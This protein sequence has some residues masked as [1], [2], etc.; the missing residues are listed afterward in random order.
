VPTKSTLRAI[1]LS[2]LMV[3][4]ILGISQA[5]GKKHDVDC[6]KQFEFSKIQLKLSA[7]VLKKI[8]GSVDLGSQVQG[9]VDKWTTISLDNQRALCDA[10]SKSTEADFPTREY[11]TQLENFRAW[12]LDFLKIV[13][14][15][16][17][18]DDK[19]A[20]AVA[21]GKGPNDPDV[22]QLKND[23]GEQIKEFVNNPPKAL[24][25]AAKEKKP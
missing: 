18:V 22:A 11:L 17:N 3:M 1:G 7:D 14:T 23:L 4:L 9:Q 21:G 8:T 2:L 16:Q 10:Y 6:N 24:P 25:A 12:Q 5:A 13:I 19:K 20:A 15:A